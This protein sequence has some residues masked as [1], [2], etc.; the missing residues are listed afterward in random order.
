MSRIAAILAWVVA[1]LLAAT[2]AH[3]CLVKADEGFGFWDA[4]PAD[5][6]ADEVALEVEFMGEVATV[7]R[8]TPKPE[9][10]EGHGLPQPQHEGQATAGPDEF[11]FSTSCGGPTAYRVKR[12]LHGAFDGDVVLAGTQ[13]IMLDETWNPLRKRILVG[14]L[15]TQP[16]KMALIMVRDWREHVF[17]G[18][19][20]EVRLA[21]KFEPST[22]ERVLMLP[23]RIVFGGARLIGYGVSFIPGLGA[24]GGNPWAGIAGLMLLLGGIGWLI[25]R[26]RKRREDRA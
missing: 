6:A 21:R 11:A 18:T 17:F 7:V 25:W 19:G 8:D 10:G 24:A 13:L 26:P 1:L 5:M 2:P 9:P 14:T 22:F 12:V 15:D 20:I 3:A 23:E 16:T 4:P